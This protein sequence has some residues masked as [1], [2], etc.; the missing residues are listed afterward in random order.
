MS[1]RFQKILSQWIHGYYEETCRD[2]TRRKPWSSPLS[3]NNML[4]E[5]DKKLEKEDYGS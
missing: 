2:S 1:S 4:N 3:S 5:L